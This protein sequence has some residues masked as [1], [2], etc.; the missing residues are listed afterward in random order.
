[1]K[2]DINKNYYKIIGVPVDATKEEIKDRLSEI[3]NEL[4]NNDYSANYILEMGKILSETEKVLLDDE[5]RDNYNAE[6]F[7]QSEKFKEFSES[8]EY[9]NPDD[10]VKV[11]DMAIAEYSKKERIA[12]TTAGLSIV[13]VIGIIVGILGAKYKTQKEHEKVINSLA[14]NS[15]ST[16]SIYNNESTQATKS[17]VESTEATESKIEVSSDEVSEN[18]WNKIQQLQASDPSFAPEITK[19][20]II[21]LVRW[22]KHDGNTIANA[23]AFGELNELAENPEFNIADITD[24]LDIDDSMNKYIDCFNNV[25][26]NGSLEDENTC[27]NDINNIS[28]TIDKN[29]VVEANMITAEMYA[30]RTQNQ[31]IGLATDTIDGT[32]DDNL[33]KTLS[34]ISTDDIV[35]NSN[36]YNEFMNSLNGALDKS[37]DEDLVLKK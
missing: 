28:T 33:R 18:V 15:Y 31:E 12:L 24:G 23:T 17:I 36:Y 5:T 21:N 8:H 29:S 1:M 11:E 14:S 3:Y 6:K 9:N 34:T 7:S 13:A 35:K 20:N 26:E 22:A 4:N 32:L 2:Y 19:N 27:I 16:E 37:D 10:A 25:A 30:K